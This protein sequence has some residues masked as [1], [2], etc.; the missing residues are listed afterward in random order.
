MSELKELKD[1]AWVDIRHMLHQAYEMGLSK[2]QAASDEYVKG[3]M[4]KA[5]K[6]GLNAAWKAA[7]RIFSPDPP[8]GYTGAEIFKIL[9]CGYHDAWKMSAEEAIP[10][11]NLYEKLKTYQAG[12]V[13]EDVG[14][15]SYLIVGS[16]DESYIVISGSDFEP[17][18]IGKELIRNYRNQNDPKDLQK[19]ID[20][21]RG[22]G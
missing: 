7:I 20:S 12:D 5:F 16:N 11:I 3:E 15:T 8:D 19:V 14:G 1:T 17:V 21:I 18:Y 6:E 22:V 4:E 10:K 13:I 9:G 2:A